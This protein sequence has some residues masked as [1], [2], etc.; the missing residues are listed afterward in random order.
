MAEYE[1]WIRKWGGKKVCETYEQDYYVLK[2]K[3]KSTDLLSVL[4]TKI[5]EV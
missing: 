1:D 4:E 3:K 5:S 2:K